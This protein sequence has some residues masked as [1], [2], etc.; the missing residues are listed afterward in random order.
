MN[1]LSTFERDMESRA[2]G[3]VF[4]L[5][6]DGSVLM[7]HRDDKPNL[8]RPGMWV[9]PGGHRNP[10]EP[11]AA[12]ARREF[13]EETGYDCDDLRW[14]TTVIDDPGGGWPA[15]PLYVYWAFYDG[16]RPLHCLEGQALK[17][18]NRN[19]AKD[20]PIPPLIFELWDRVLG[21]AFQRAQK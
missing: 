10:N 15:Y 3:T 13:L 21:V 18:L 17:F 8:C 2:V 6:R 7:Q 9:P 20:Y 4:L 16:K 12:C 5:R 11:M 19:E 14:L 1:T